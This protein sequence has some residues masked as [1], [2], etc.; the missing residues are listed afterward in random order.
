MYKVYMLWTHLKHKYITA[1]Y[2]I[3]NTLSNAYVSF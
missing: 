2:I 3:V 1:V